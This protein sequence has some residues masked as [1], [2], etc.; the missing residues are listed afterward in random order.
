MLFLAVTLG[1]FVENQREHIVEHQRA[2]QFAKALIEDLEKDT[3]EILDVI[4]E[5]KII[6]LAF[7]SV[8]SIIRRGIT[9]NKVHGSFY[10]YCNVVTSAPSVL[11]NDATL[12]QVTQSGSLRYFT[13]PELV[14]KI[15]LYFSQANYVKMLNATDKII[16]DKSMEIRSRIL[17]NYEFSRFSIFS[18]DNR[19]AVPD[20]LINNLFPVQ[21]NDLNQLNEFANSFE[22]RKRT[23]DLVMKRVYPAAIKNARELISLLKKE[24]H[25]E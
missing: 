3:V 1:F 20:S 9:G 5:D 10:Y 22:N 21:S 18:S 25:L 4:R 24:Y 2:K 11:W 19:L 16:R 8:S 15:S 14:K 7:D 13:N 17:N 6:L 23:I 12:I